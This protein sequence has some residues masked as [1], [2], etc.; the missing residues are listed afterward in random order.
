MIG[1]SHAIDLPATCEIADLDRLAMAMLKQHL[2]GI[3]VPVM[4]SEADAR[5]DARPIQVKCKPALTQWPSAFG[6]VCFCTARQPRTQYVCALAILW[7][8]PLTQ[9]QHKA[10][11]FQKPA[12][13][14]VSMWL[15]PA[16][17]MK[18]GKELDAICRRHPILF[19]G[20]DGI[21]NR[22]LPTGTYQE[23]DHVDEWGCVWSNVHDGMEAYVTG[24]PV[25]TREA[26]HTLKAPSVIKPE[27]KHG[28]MYLRLADLR[29]FEELML[30]FA[31]DAPE[32]QMLIDIVLD[33]VMKR[34]E[35]LDKT[36]G[37]EELMRFADDLG[38]QTSLAMGADKWRK[39]MKPCF[40]KIYG[41]WRKAGRV[42][43]MHT[44]GCIWEIIPDLQE[45]G[46]QIINP[47][48]RANGIDNLVRVCKDNKLCACL[49]LD[50]QMFP[51]ASPSDID[52]HVKECVAKLGSKEGGLWLSGE[53]APDVP[54][55][56][57]EALCSALEKYRTYWS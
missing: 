21:N 29:G 55:D 48:V 32:L 3:R 51:F 17:W 20:Y 22:G 27:L 35:L 23:G 56:N 25:P 6:H 54:P 5:Q 24:H 8:M 15:L 37:K 34:V 10:T 42:V 7:A 19:P 38:M 12:A 41:Y 33:H 47:Q 11:F 50:R 40:A 14:P 45:C 13:I 1:S 18:Y 4:P 57:I 31:E 26:V 2:P 16:T 46:V 30:D 9:D 28:F 52:E 39:Y 53:C 43:F 44:D 36:I 49:D